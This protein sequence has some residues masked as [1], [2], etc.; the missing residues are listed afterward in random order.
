LINTNRSK[1]F[2][3]LV[4][5]SIAGLT[6][7]GCG[8]VSPAV[9]LLSGPNPTPTSRVVEKMVVVT[10]SG[11]AVEPAEQQPAPPSVS[12]SIQPGDDVETQILKAVY[13]KVNPSVV[14]IENLTPLT[15]A[16]NSGTIVPESQGS[17]FVWDM[18]GH[19]VTND[20]VVR[21]ATAIQVT[22]S[23]GVVLPATVVGTDPDSDLAV[24]TVD[25]TLVNLV[26]VER[27]DISKVEVGQRAV[28]IGNPFGFVGTMTSGIVS[29]IGRSI[30]AIT[31][32]S[33]PR[34][35]QTDAPINP[36]NSGGPLLNE[37]GQVIGVNAQ[38]RSD[39]RSN[40]GVG[41]AI[42]IN[43][44]ERVAPA[45]IRDGVYQHAFLGI[46]GQTYSP[47]WA[48]ALGF[49]RSARGAYVITVS[50]GGPA[51]KGGLQPGSRNTDIVLGL[52]VNGPEYLPAGG[53]LITAIDDQPVATF[54]DLLV[55][56]ESFKSPN[57]V[58]KLKVI[59]AG[60]GER[61]LSITLGQRPKTV[62]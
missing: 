24:I 10:P 49:P 31:G 22:F 36:G 46:S 5:F 53:D 16:D 57:D 18:E 50:N 38:I 13:K 40:S 15:S 58:V 21:D 11:I 27:G 20:H 26:P 33:I 25:P 45:L 54:D 42:P 28:A 61:E 56:L 37:R 1:Q 14:S 48:E 3:T 34:A 60:E 2:L 30:P 9:R 8:L 19:I 17:G 29:A 59:R 4:A 62:P 35:I 32:F 43:I 55:Y 52:G 47:A 6:L 51:S 39:S 12:I 7:M 44:V 41:F 23:D